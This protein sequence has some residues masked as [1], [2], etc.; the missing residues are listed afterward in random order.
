ME[1]FYF[2]KS[3]DASNLVIR[4]G[5]WDLKSE[6][7]HILH[8]DRHVSKVIKHEK[9]YGGASYNDIA[10]V[11][12]N[13][14]FIL[15]DNVGTICL[16]PQGYQFHTERCHVSGWGK[17]AVSM[18]TIYNYYYLCLLKIYCTWCLKVVIAVEYYL[19]W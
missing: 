7:E 1:C 17:N 2:Y 15:D 6:D 8:Q 18:C 14:K 13:E 11:I 19:L 4:A 3:K 12:L 5:E 9:Y 10:L 16:P